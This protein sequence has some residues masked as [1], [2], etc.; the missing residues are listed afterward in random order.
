MRSSDFGALDAYVQDNS[1]FFVIVSEITERGPVV[2]VLGQH[3]N[4]QDEQNDEDFLAAVSSDL[5]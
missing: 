3:T 2:V 1:D 4:W 5:S